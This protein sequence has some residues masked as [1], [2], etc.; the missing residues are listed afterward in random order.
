MRL[1]RWLLVLGLVALFAGMAAANWGEAPVRFVLPDGSE[2]QLRL[3][4]L[5]IIAFL[6]GW[7]PPWLWHL[8]SRAAWTRQ[9]R[10][11]RLPEPAR[12]P[13]GDGLCDQAQPTIVPPVA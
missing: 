9:A 13:A 4:L 5:L 6:A 3:P 1:L 2:A 12:E 8:G 7:L 10:A 11:T